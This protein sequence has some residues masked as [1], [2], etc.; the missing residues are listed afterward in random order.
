MQVS[1]R[2]K[3]SLAGVSWVEAGAGDGEGQVIGHYLVQSRTSLM[4]YVQT[5]DMARI[6]F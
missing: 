4:I 3:S 5:E 6:T 2:E 1:F